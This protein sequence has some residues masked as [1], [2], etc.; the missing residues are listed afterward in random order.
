MAQSITITQDEIKTWLID[1]LA[2]RLEME[3]ADIDINEP[4]DNYDLDYSQALILL[5]RL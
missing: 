5:G 1:Q 4:F 3:P 2:E